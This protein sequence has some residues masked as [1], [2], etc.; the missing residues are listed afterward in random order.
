MQKEI[1]DLEWQLKEV[2][3]DNDYYQEENKRLEE[4]IEKMKNCTNCDNED[5]KYC[6]SAGSCKNK[7]QWKLKE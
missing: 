2:V 6:R 1:K 7:D 3:K 5:G 4:Q